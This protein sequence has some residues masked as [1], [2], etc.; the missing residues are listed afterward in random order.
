MLI[1]EGNRAMARRITTAIGLASLVSAVVVLTPTVA[2][3]KQ[4]CTTLSAPG[5]GSAAVCK[6]WF[7]P[8][9][10]GYYYG[11]WWP[12]GPWTTKV[13]LKKIEDGRQRDADAGGRDYYNVKVFQLKLCNT[14]TGKC[15]SPW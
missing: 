14:L 2:N 13:A 4:Q 10:D 12:N 8:D 3:A 9:G 6:S 1:D 11:S 7:D 5:G 15:G